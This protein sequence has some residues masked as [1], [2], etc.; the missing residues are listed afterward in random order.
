[1][2]KQGLK[3]ARSQTAL[4]LLVLALP[5]TL[6]TYA[7]SPEDTKHNPNSSAR[8]TRSTGTPRSAIQSDPAGTPIYADPCN[9]DWESLEASSQELAESFITVQLKAPSTAK[10]QRNQYYIERF[11]PLYR[12]DGSQV[13]LV[14]VHGVTDSQNSFGVFLRMNWQ[15]YL[16]CEGGALTVARCTIDG[17]ELFLADGLRELIESSSDNLK[18][19]QIREARD[20]YFRLINA[21]KMSAEL[22]QQKLESLESDNRF[23]D[24]YIDVAQQLKVLQSYSDLDRMPEIQNRIADLEA[25]LDEIG[26]IPQDEIDAYQSAHMELVN[27]V[28]DKHQEVRILERELEAEIKRIESLY[29]Q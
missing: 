23:I 24:E 10:H 4:A 18:N 22:A 25:V 27:L 29:A 15:V 8:R 16:A 13:T 14:V 26:E 6:C 7:C 1:M 19:K 11:Q 20:E 2:N 28:R 9:S 17:E 5:F 21:A 12:E 3:L